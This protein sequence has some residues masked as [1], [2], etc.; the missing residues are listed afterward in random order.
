MPSWVTDNNNNNDTTG[1]SDQADLAVLPIHPLSRQ[2]QL[3]QPIATATGPSLSASAGGMEGIE[4]QGEEVEIVDMRP[5][6]NGELVEI[7][8]PI[9]R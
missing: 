6:E 5:T 1:M 7:T 8:K 4:E 9:R 3:D 2:L